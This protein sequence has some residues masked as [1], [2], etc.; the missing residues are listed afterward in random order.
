VSAEDIVA[1]SICIPLALGILG[2]FVHVLVDETQDKLWPRG[3]RWFPG[4][5]LDLG[6]AL[7]RLVLRIFWPE[8][9][10]TFKGR[11]ILRLE[12][13]D[14]QWRT[15]YG[16]KERTGEPPR[17]APYPGLTDQGRWEPYSEDKHG[18]TPFLR[19]ESQWLE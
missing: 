4:L 11:K 2:L 1:M 7:H 18:K 5:W 14:S 16:M 9:L 19:E 8:K 10:R 13:Y 15:W 3:L 17:W 6:E 12:S